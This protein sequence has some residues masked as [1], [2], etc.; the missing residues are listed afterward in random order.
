MRWA[1]SLAENMAGMHGERSEPEPQISV[2]KAKGDLTSR[3]VHHAGLRSSEG[4]GV[5]V[6]ELLSSITDIAKVSNHST[7]SLSM[8]LPVRDQA[9]TLQLLI[10]PSVGTFPPHVWS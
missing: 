7:A 1:S 10:F 6:R 4:G 5:A 8:S 3:A 2:I 9:L